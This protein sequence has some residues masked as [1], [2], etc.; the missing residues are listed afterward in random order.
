MQGS[1]NLIVL[2][3]AGAATQDLG[4]PELTYCTLHVANLALSWCGSLHP[5]GGLTSDTTNHV[6]MC[7][8]LGG[9]LL[10]LGGEGG[11]R[12]L[13]DTRVQRRGAAGDQKI[14][15][16]LITGAG[17]AIAIAGSRASEGRMGVERG[18]HCCYCPRPKLERER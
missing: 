2:L 10:R 11:R 16:A 6:G 3:K 14:V 5:L 8:G 13:G 15:R 7:E 12:R 1:C 17:P 9:T 4:Q 18:S